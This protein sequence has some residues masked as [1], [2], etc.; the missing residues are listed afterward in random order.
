MAAAAS[1]RGNLSRTGTRRSRSGAR[2]EPPSPEPD[3]VF[4]LANSPNS[5]WS[6]RQ[7]QAAKAHQAAK[8]PESEGP[9][10][11]AES[12]KRRSSLGTDLDPG[13]VSL[14]SISTLLTLHSDAENI[15]RE[16]M[17]QKRVRTH[18]TIRWDARHVTLTSE[19]LLVRNEECGE[20]REIIPLLDMSTV[21]RKW[22][23]PRDEK[24]ASIR[25][26]AADPRTPGMGIRMTPEF[27]AD[28]IALPMTPSAGAEHGGDSNS[29]AENSP[30][31]K[32][33]NSR[34]WKDILVPRKLSK[35][36]S[37]GGTTSDKED[38]VEKRS[39]FEVEWENVLEISCDA[40]ARTYYLK[41]PSQGTCDEWVTAV[42]KAR[43]AAQERYQ[44]SLNLTAQQRFRLKVA[45]FYEHRVTQSCI[46]LL[47]G[48]NFIINVVQTELEGY[49]MDKQGAVSEDLK[50]T[51]DVINLVFTVIYTVEVSVNLLAHWFWPFV[52]SLWCLF[53]LAIVVTSLVEVV[54]VRMGSWDGMDV[55]LLRL[56]RIFRVLRV[57]NK[58]ALPPSLPCP[59]PFLS[60]PLR[61]SRGC[62]K[63]DQ[64]LR[65][66]G[67]DRWREATAQSS[68]RS[69]SAPA[70]LL[71][72]PTLSLTPP[73]HTHTHTHTHEHK[74]I[75]T[76]THTQLSH[77]LSLTAEG[78]AANHS[79][80]GR[81]V[82]ARGIGI[83]ALHRPH[84]R[85]RGAGQP[86]VCRHHLR[87]R[88]D[89]GLRG[90]ALR[91]LQQRLRLDARH[92]YRLRLLDQSHAQL[93]RGPEI[94]A[95]RN[96]DLLHQLRDPRRHRRD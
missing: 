39:V 77:T 4:V 53:D 82:E 69:S 76:Q 89:Q 20:V 19:C 21:C 93:I 44:E 26:L 62:R 9:L 36:G 49:D 70:R 28:D 16:G 75:H 71:T 81:L 94:R 14:G 33:T 30:A 85:V 15:L 56:L 60:L 42:L 68:G 8:G 29:P 13:P 86:H 63:Q 47:L 88:R 90:G 2:S 67:V 73:A 7:A 61:T 58:V 23:K 10:S 87:Q 74:H 6:R 24:A 41:A 64:H 57:F 84:L 96:A 37:K 52:T 1:T 40:Y 83:S 66:C 54:A 17:L 11:R 27:L 46:A 92:C 22:N 65:A 48:L 34:S 95:R 25:T 35:K 80:G 91:H 31:E 43:E 32:S 3:D 38:G 59:W 79:S 55:N 51:F 78:P 50:Q 12:R 45:E 5:M 18:S 72:R